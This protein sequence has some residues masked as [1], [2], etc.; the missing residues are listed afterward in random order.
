MRPEQNLEMEKDFE[1][2]AEPPQNF[3]G[4]ESETAESEYS[5]EGQSDSAAGETP[6]QLTWLKGGDEQIV[7]DKLDQVRDASHLMPPVADRLEQFLDS[8]VMSFTR[9]QLIAEQNYTPKQIE[10][11]FFRLRKAGII[12]ASHR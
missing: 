7:R 5:Q 6:P 10:S 2:Q 8:G 9:E 4:Y 11:V 12:Y 1:N 3:Y